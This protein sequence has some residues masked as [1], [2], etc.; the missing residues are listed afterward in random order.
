MSRS[1]ITLQEARSGRPVDALD[2]AR[3]EVSSRDLGWDGMA[4]EV[5]ENDDW[6]VTGIAT[7]D[8]Y[9]AVH[10]GGSAS[11]TEF[12]AGTSLQPIHP[13][14]GEVWV[15][16]AEH[17]FSWR[18]KGTIRYAGLTLSPDL[19]ARL[20]GADGLDIPMSRYA[21]DPVL[22]HLVRALVAEAEA[23]GPNGP[24]FAQTLTIAVS[25]HLARRYAAQAPVGSSGPGGL[26][27]QQLRRVQEYIDA[28]LTTDVSLDDMAE[29][30]ALSPHHFARA[31]KASVGVPPYRYFMQRR[32]ERARELLLAGRQ[33]IGEVAAALGFADPSH[34][35]RTFKRHFGITP[36]K[37]IKEAAR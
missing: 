32:A 28:H 4:V 3:I 14:P 36:S 33:R 1:V 17:P 27:K 20:S 37:L 29:Q 6:D 11:L 23:G 30:A 13:R 24:A 22:A 16:G 2:N 35:T 34:L 18:V 21:D 8:H 10:L 31:F 25:T 5:G 9:I 12:G 26:S 7:A 19:A 15:S